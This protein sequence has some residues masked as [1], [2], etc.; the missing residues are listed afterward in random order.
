MNPFSK[1][2]LFQ[3]RNSIDIHWL[4][5]EKLIL[6]RQ[7]NGIWRFRCPL[8][9]G[10]HTAIAKKTNLA[11]CFDCQ[12]NFNT[13][14]LVIFSKHTNFVPA[15]KWLLSLLDTTNVSPLND[16]QKKESKPFDR[17]L[18]LREI[19]RMKQIIR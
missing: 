13:I 18:A 9:Q 10:F 7:F 17:K 4:I 19:E 6:E 16:L 2:H 1:Q 5:N 3:V 15:V 12:K 11:R 14:D 8:C